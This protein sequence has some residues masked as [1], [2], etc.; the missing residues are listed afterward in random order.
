MSRTGLDTFTEGSN[1]ALESHTSDSGTQ[2]VLVQSDTLGTNLATVLA[3]LDVVSATTAGGA[4]GYA[5]KLGGPAATL[6]EGHGFRIEADM[7]MST[8]SNTEFSYIW[9]RG[10]HTT[11][12]GTGDATITGY[13]AGLLQSAGTQYLA[14][15]RWNNFAPGGPSTLAVSAISGYSGSTTY[16][17][18]LELHGDGPS[19]G[20]GVQISVFLDDVLTITHSDTGASRISSGILSGL[21]FR[22][23]SGTTML[24]DNWLAQHLTQARRTGQ[25]RD[26]NRRGMASRSTTRRLAAQRAGVWGP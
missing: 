18:R 22:K 2:W 5:Y 8:S 17:V 1:T 20:K 19:G 21:V 3:S 7:R 9:A 16:N 10:S 12:I 4:T 25:V 26:L 14:L 11:V 23:F 24:Q 15:G 13:G 6:D